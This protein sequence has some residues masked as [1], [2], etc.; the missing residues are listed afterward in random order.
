MIAARQGELLAPALDQVDELLIR[1]AV[2]SKPSDVYSLF[3]PLSALDEKE[4]AEVESKNATTIKTYADT[5]IMP[6]TALA[7]IAKNKIIE[8]GNWPGSEAAF[9]EAE[10]AGDDP[11]D[12]ANQSNE[13]DLPAIETVPPVQ[14]QPKR[15]KQPKPVQ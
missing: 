5:G 12:P 14:P 2:G 8:G 9:E 1:S 11:L 10:A 7:K 13:A 15:G 4:A 3:A 6:D